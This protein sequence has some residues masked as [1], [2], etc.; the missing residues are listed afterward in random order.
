[1]RNIRYVW[2]ISLVNSDDIDGMKVSENKTEKKSDK[3]IVTSS[4]HS[5]K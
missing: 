5:G 3:K 1:V 4:Y 2:W